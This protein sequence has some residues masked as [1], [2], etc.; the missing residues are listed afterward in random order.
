[1]TARTPIVACE[2][3]AEEMAVKLSEQLFERGFFVK[4]I[5]YPTVPKDCARLRITIMA[6]H[7][8]EHL[9]RFA[10]TL[11]GLLKETAGR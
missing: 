4:A 8:R 9:E 1:M 7:T 6:L 3:G 10:G 2:V 11:A 5:R